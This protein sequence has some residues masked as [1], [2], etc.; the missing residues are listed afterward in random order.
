MLPLGLLIQ[1][2]SL[3]PLPSM[4]RCP[5]AVPGATHGSRFMESLGR[6][7]PGISPAT[8][9]GGCEGGRGRI[10]RLKPVSLGFRTS[11]L[12]RSPFPGRLPSWPGPGGD[13]WVGRGIR[14]AVKRVSAQADGLSVGC[15]DILRVC[16]CRGMGVGHCRRGGGGVVSG[17][18]GGGAAHLCGVLSRPGPLF[19]P[20]VQWVSPALTRCHLCK[21]L[22]GCKESDRSYRLNNN[23][24]VK[25]S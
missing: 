1:S 7:G 2:H 19:P 11:C 3:W 10:H 4:L 20:S 25:L 9:Q 8:R 22:W 15:R 24:N 16:V 23:K 17:G 13:W 18:G 14:A 21:P 6:P 12:P 5:L